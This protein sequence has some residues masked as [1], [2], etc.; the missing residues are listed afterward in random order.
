M[1]KA[2]EMKQRVYTLFAENVKNNIVTG[3]GIVI[4][5]K[6]GFNKEKLDSCKSEFAGYLKEIGADEHQV[7]SLASL[8]KT[9]DGEV[10][11][12]LQTI[13]DFQALDLFLGF[14]NACGFI[15][16]SP[17]VMTLNINQMGEINSILVS[18]HGRE[19]IGDD[20]KYMKLIREGVAN[21]MFFISNIKEIDEFAPAGPSAQ[22]IK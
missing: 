5:R 17:E 10:W 9:K 21:N 7:V 12:E 4:N 3:N 15:V 19:F 22:G 2:N 13:E 8:A 1:L 14:V 16:N 11:N 20:K 6:L 18:I